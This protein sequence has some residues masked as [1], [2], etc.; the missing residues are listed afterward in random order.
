MIQ[1]LSSSLITHVHSSHP[2]RRNLLFPRR[3]CHQN[4]RVVKQFE[5]RRADI[6]RARHPFDYIDGLSDLLQARDKANATPPVK[7]NDAS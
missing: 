1:R 5:A 7:E 6:D 3:G 4:P 2:L